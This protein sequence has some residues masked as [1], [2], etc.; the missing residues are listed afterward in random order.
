MKQAIILFSFIT[1]FSC[2]EV[3][4]EEVPS[5]SPSSIFEQAWA[6]ADQEY[7][8]FKFKNIDWDSV[9]QEFKPLV[10]DNMSDE[11]LFRVL[12]DM[13]FLL[14][15]GHVNLK[16]KFDRSRNWEWY[17]GFPENFNYS[18]LERNYF[19]SEEQFVG[20]FTVYDFGDVGY[21]RY[22][23]FGNSVSNDNLDYVIDQF[24]GHK[25]LII[26]V[27]NNGG[28][29]LG[30]AYKIAKRFASREK[31]V[32]LQYFKD[33]PNHNDLDG[34]YSTDITPPEDLPTYLKPVVVL[35]N[36]H[37]FSATTFFTQYMRE[38]DNVTIMGD[39]TG[40]GGGAPSFTELSNGW[41][42]RVSS[43]LTTDPQGF[44][45]EDGIPP[46]IKVDMNKE[47]EDAGKDTI[48]E[49]ALKLLRQ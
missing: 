26:D 34:P 10:D 28:G 8:F 4:F 3:F 7:T 29:F 6:F 42:L 47:D 11:E 25:G 1:F 32:A 36:R 14:R 37:S 20:S 48:L 46:D 41:E 45:I 33:G 22:S 39:W 24:D 9:Y 27:R 35:T 17:L 44:N 49:E 13:L 12:A 19:M 21:L 16:S 31:R 18:L 23:S 30:N 38:L 2:E 15:D 5:D 43:T 40:G